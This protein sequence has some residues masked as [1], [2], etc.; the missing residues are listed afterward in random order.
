M[1]GQIVGFSLKEELVLLCPHSKYPL[2]VQARKAGRG[3]GSSSAIITHGD[4]GWVGAAGGENQ[5]GIQALF[6][7]L[8]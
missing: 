5:G 2:T 6:F 3:T 7:F 4:W 8:M 1:K